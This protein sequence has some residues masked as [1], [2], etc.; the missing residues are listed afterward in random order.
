M[1]VVFFCP[2]RQNEKLLLLSKDTS[3]TNFPHKSKVKTSRAYC[4]IEQ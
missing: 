1:R 4:F 2:S 3:G